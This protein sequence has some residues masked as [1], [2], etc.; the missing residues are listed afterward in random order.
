MA[1]LKRVIENLRKIEPMGGALSSDAKV[2]LEA[3]RRRS[4]V[5]GIVMMLVLLAA[6]VVTANASLLHVRDPSQIKLVSGGLGLSL[7]A[8]LILLRSTW[9]E[10]SQ[11]SLL[12]VLVQDA[13]DPQIGALLD[14]L[15]AK[16]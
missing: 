10:W 7:G 5:A 1:T 12:L 8:A 3:H 16:L 2:A 11:T 4:A 13:D 15:A 9:R 6:V 14:K